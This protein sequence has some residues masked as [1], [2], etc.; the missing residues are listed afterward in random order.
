MMTKT[1][2][3]T[4]KGTKLK[5][6]ATRFQGHR[7]NKQKPRN[8]MKQVIQEKVTGTDGRETENEADETTKLRNWTKNKNKK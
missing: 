6:K 1:K 2:Q 7:Q 8:E 5:T 3:K 4:T